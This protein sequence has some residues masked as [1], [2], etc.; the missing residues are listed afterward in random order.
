MPPLK[1][2]VILNI[3]NWGTKYFRKI[4]RELWISPRPFFWLLLS[5]LWSVW[6]FIWFKVFLK[7]F[8]DFI[9]EKHSQSWKLHKVWG[10]REV[11]FW[12]MFQWLKHKIQ[13]ELVI[14]NLGKFLTLVAF[15]NEM[16]PFAT[17]LI[18]N[19]F[20]KIGKIQK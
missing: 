18:Y 12:C 1:I 4:I 6:Y 9:I 16:V 8:W 2:I 14:P 3:K 11:F 20:Y 17:T 19:I 5:C 13:W 7:L 10:G 15:F